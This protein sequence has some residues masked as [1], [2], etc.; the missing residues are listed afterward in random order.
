MYVLDI[1]ERGR[2]ERCKPIESDRSLNFLECEGRV[3]IRT[4]IE[5]FRVIV[6][7]AFFA[8]FASAHFYF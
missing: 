5:N 1:F 6:F 3:I 4:T 7:I 8:A 2:G